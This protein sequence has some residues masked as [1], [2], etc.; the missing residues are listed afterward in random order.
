MVCVYIMFCAVTTPLPEATTDLG[1]IEPVI[2]VS[3]CICSVL[4]GG[5]AGAVVVVLDGGRAA[6]SF[7]GTA[8][9]DP[10]ESPPSSDRSTSVR[11]RFARRQP[12]G[13]RAGP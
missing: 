9:V 3:F 6:S 10:E 8:D 5:R 2:V 11:S 13:T 4:A 1:E 12:A 7:A